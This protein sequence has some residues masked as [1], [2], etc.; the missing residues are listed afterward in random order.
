[1]SQEL[2]MRR[3]AAR[4]VPRVLSNDQKEHRVAICAELKEQTEN[5]P[6]FISTI[7]TGDES[8]VYEYNSEAKQQSSQWKTPNSPLPKKLQVLNNVKSIIF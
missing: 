8:W 1:M 5:N 7:I 3:I 2:N 4:F 6:N